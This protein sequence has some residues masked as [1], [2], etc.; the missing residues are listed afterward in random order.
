METLLSKQ[1]YD[2]NELEEKEIYMGLDIGSVSVKIALVDDKKN[3]LYTAYQRHHGQPNETALEMLDTMKGDYP[4]WSITNVSI[5]GLSATLAGSR[6]SITSENEIVCQAKA[7]SLLYPDVRSIIEIGGQDSKLIL[8]DYDRDIDDVIINDFAMNTIC[9]AGTGSFLDQQATR[10]GVSIQKEFGELA[11]RSKKPPRV[12]GRCS[13]FAKSDMIHLQQVGTPVHDVVAGLCFAMAR[14]FVSGIARGKKISL[15]VAFHG[16]VAS[17]AGMTRAFRE[18]MGVDDGHLRIHEHHKEMGAIGAALIAR[19]RSGERRFDMEAFRRFFNR[20]TEKPESL[21]PLKIKHSRISTSPGKSYIPKNGD[22][23]EGYLGVDVGSISTNL[24]V[25]DARGR[26]L[27]KK[28]LMTAGRPLEA[29]KTGL[30]EIGEEL[31]DRIVIEGVSTTGSGRYLTGDFLGADVVKNEITAQ[32]RGASIIDSRVD[33]I[34]EIGGQDSKFISLDDGAIVDF[35]MNKV[36][37]AGTG[38]FLEEQAEKLGINIE[39]EF[40]KKAM[41]AKLPC[42]M[43][44]RCTVFIES[45]IVSNQ[46]KGASCEDLLAGLSYSIVHNYLNKVVADKRVGNRIFFQGGTAFNDSVVA[47]FEAITGKRI[48]VPDHHEVTGAIGCALIAREWHR[49][50]GKKS[51]FRGFELSHRHYEQDSFEC[52]GCSNRCEIK[53]IRIEGEKPLFYGGRCEK[54]ETRHNDKADQI[55]DLFS[56]RE[57]FLLREYNSQDAAKLCRGI[58]GIPRIMYFFDQLPFWTRFFNKLGY[59]VLLSD[60]TNRHLINA[61]LEKI[62]SESCFPI[63]VSHGHIMNLIEKDV[64]FIFI[65]S[66]LGLKKVYKNFP[67]SIVC[68]YGQALPYMLNIALD[69]DRQDKV[70][71]LSPALNFSRGLRSLSADLRPIASQLGIH[72]K[73][74]TRALKSAESAQEEFHQLCQKRGMEILSIIDEEDNAAVI[75]SRPYNGCDPGLNLELPRKLR[76]LNALPIPMDFLPLDDVPIDK[77]WPFMTWRYGQKIL[78]AAEIVRNDRRLNAIFITNFGCGPDSF[79]MKFFRKRMGGKIYLTLEVDEHSADAGA[80]TRCEAFLDSIKNCRDRE[81]RKYILE[82]RNF[83]RAKEKRTIYMSYMCDHAYA[84][85][86]AFIGVGIPAEVLPESDMETLY[87]GRKFTNGKECYPCIVTTGD[88]VKFLHKKGVDPNKVAFFMPTAGGGCRFGYYNVLQRIVLQDLGLSDVPI[89][90]PHQT[91]SFMKDL[92]AVG[93]EDFFRLAW[94]AIVAMDVLGKALRETRPYE[95]KKGQTHSVYREY[96]H[97]ICNATMKKERLVPILKKSRKAF[98]QIPVDKQ[99]RPVIGIVGEIF[100]RTNRFSNN[101]LVENLE[102]LGAEVWVAPF[103]EWIFYLNLIKKEDYLQDNDYLEWLKLKIADSVARKDEHAIVRPFEGFLRSAHEPTIEENVRMGSNYVE[104]SFRGESILSLGKAVDY[105]RSGLS[106]VINT[107]PFTCM[108][109]T[110]VNSLLKRV[111]QDCEDIPMLNVAYD[112]LDMSNN[113]LRLEAFVHQ[114][115]QYMEKNLK[116]CGVRC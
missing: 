104:P 91:D 73:E 5:T 27:S 45:D 69:L 54:Y 13:V 76:N 8:I 6:S 44:E 116:L 101:H 3:I 111:K 7:S 68:P 43:G 112:G 77:D 25:I 20:S 106:G 59:Q 21:P 4:L 34:F 88:L 46:Q 15:P 1:S 36:C 42:A 84:L 32:A 24:V 39:R 16:G 33:T 64:E 94:K 65:P 110:V 100:V 37:A 81:T 30:A 89:Y 17:N 35:E 83:D 105:Y 67:E 57:E 38:S 53:R 56:E 23:I 18:V 107:M 10:L 87:W 86:A 115:R 61:G 58:I 70:K 51:T 47:A 48:I 19:E 14:N 2:T 22:K 40:A 26:L 113:S 63:K 92:G 95:L 28:Y 102:D 75:I 31:G 93:G 11:L 62:L 99:V 85:R 78:A 55:P 60:P 97:K 114:C 29:V 98:E 52:K 49:N 66:I 71:I 41:R 80:I 74:I 50:T 103:A 108:P 109:G 96:L 12:A 9:A 79:M 82:V 90:S 72:Y